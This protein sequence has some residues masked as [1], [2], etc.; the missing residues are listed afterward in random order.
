MNSTKLL[1][2]SRVFFLLAAAG[3]CMVQVIC[4]GQINPHLSVTQPGGMP[5]VPVMTG[6]ERSSNGM[7]LTWD[8]PSGY[9]QLFQ[10][11]RLEDTAWQAVGSRTN[12]SRTATVAGVGEQAYFR[13]SGPAAQFAG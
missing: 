5:G 1:L 13:V 7:V 11:S 6:I 12:F 9:Y 4:Q 2:K 10:K 8:G 3:F